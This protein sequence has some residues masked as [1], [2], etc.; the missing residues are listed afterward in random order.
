LVGASYG[1]EHEGASLGVYQVGAG[2]ELQLTGAVSHH[3]GSRVVP[4]RQG[5]AH[6]HGA[7]PGRNGLVYVCDLGMDTVFVYRLGS[8]GEAKELSRTQTPPGC[9]PRH[10]AVHPDGHA[11]YVLCELSQDVLTYHHRA[12]DG[13]EGSSDSAALALQ[14]TSS[15]L[16]GGA[17]DG[18]GSKAGEIL[19]S[20]DGSALFATNRGGAQNTVTSFSTGSGSLVWV[21][22]VQAPAFPRGMVLVHGGSVLLVA[23][24]S[25]TELVSYRVLPGAKLE[26]TG[27]SLTSGLPPH[28]AALAVLP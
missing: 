5:A 10:A 13:K 8:G 15:L 17:G 16:K 28:P 7:F 9:G 2:C 4:W 20:P 25:S 22:Q 26:A 3:G 1:D 21:Q 19:I 23:G 14:Q 27:H 24:Q 6:V 11:V 12:S 18:S